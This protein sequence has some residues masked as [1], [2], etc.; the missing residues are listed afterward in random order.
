M[1]DMVTGKSPSITSQEGSLHST[2]PL[3]DIALQD[4]HLACAACFVKADFHQRHNV[5]KKLEDFG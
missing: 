2:A 4:F 3:E 5:T 1:P